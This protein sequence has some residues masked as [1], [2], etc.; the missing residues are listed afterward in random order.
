[1]PVLGAVLLLQGTSQA[2]VTLYAEYHLG[3]ASSTGSDTS[4][5]GR[6]I[7]STVSG[8][9][10]FAT[11][12]PS[13]IST[14]YFDTSAAG[15]Q[16]RW[17]TGV[18]AALPTDNFA[19][20]VWARAAS[21][22]PT[23]QGNI[24]SVGDG[25]LAIGLGANGWTAGV[26]NAST[27]TVDTSNTLGIAGG[28]GFSVDTWTSLAVIRQNGV[29]TFYINGVAQSGT[30]T[31]SGTNGTGYLSMN[32]N[33]TGNI[34]DG[35]LDEARVATFSGTDSTAS[36]LSALNAVPEPSTALLGALGALALLRRRR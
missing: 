3:E 16:G 27:Q 5:N 28:S 29:T 34:Y 24:F 7:N 31:A 12:S 14:T 9:G 2:A 35:L 15:D 6:H 21:A 1:M 11:T 10:T 30:I 32:P 36:I 13:P 23:N 19:L 22:A 4:G 33:A 17:G 26:W 25:G 20:S 8:G 18:F